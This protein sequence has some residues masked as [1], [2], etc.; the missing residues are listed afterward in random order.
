MYFSLSYSQIS[1]TTGGWKE[2]PKQ[3]A[4][5]FLSFLTEKKLWMRS[6]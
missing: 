6:L 4:P 5:V 3:I 2:E 1:S